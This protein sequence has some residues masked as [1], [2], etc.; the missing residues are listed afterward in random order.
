[1]RNLW[2]VTEQMLILIGVGLIGLQVTFLLEFYLLSGI[3]A[4]MLLLA[5]GV[6][7]LQFYDKKRR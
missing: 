2:E 6:I 1:M 7:M 3:I 5:S 4:C